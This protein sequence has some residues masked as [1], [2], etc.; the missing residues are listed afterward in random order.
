M[1]SRGSREGGEIRRVEV[2]V[3]VPWYDPDALCTHQGSTE[4]ASGHRVTPGAR[5]NHNPQCQS[6]LSLNFRL[7]LL[8]QKLVWCYNKLALLV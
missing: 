4:N 5:L 2:N 7:L 1:R 6:L 8:K 3:D